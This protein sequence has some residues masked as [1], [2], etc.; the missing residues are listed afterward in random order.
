MLL[1][2]TRAEQI[3][4]A[5]RHR[6]SDHPFQETVIGQVMLFVF[7]QRNPLASILFVVA[8]PA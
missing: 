7:L 2:Q 4:P 3:A 5:P 8:L 1:T 6:L